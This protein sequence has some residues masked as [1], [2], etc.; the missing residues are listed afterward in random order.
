MRVPPRF[1]LFLLEIQLSL[2]LGRL[3]TEVS[4]SHT[5]RHTQHTHTAHSVGLLWTSDHLVAEA[6][7]N[8]T[9]NNHKGRT[10]TPSAGHEPA[11]LEIKWLNTCVRTQGHRYRHVTDAHRPFLFASKTLITY[12]IFPPFVFFAVAD[13]FKFS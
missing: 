11:I 4:R 5:I 12:N 7:T 2:G 6:A 10:S 8:T 9:H 13:N 3:I 1:Y